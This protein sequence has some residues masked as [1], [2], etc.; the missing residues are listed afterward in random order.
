MGKYHPSEF[1]PNGVPTDLKTKGL[2]SGLYGAQEDGAST[3]GAEQL[4]CFCRVARQAMDMYIYIM[5]M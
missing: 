4:R 3:L 2:R 5:C 1:Q